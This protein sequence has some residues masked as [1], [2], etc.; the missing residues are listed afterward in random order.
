MS[1]EVELT[2]VLR[3][4][5]AAVLGFVIGR[6]REV[7]EA[8]N[9]A[10]T[11]ALAAL[12]A[13]TLVALTEAL[14]PDETARVVAGIVTGIGFLGAGTILRSPSGEVQGLTTA[15]SLWAMSAIGMAVGSGHEL[16]GV[17]LALVIY[18]TMA[19]SK[20]PVLIRL[21]QLRAQKQAKA[22]GSQPCP[23]PPE[24]EASDSPPTA[25]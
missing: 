14:Y 15:A 5:L 19:I 12:T 6:E 11:V 17:L 13:A 2:I 22:A 9:R 4:A 3:A 1:L 18:A 21:G 25:K 7:L 10:R 8:G 24:G 16:L 23:L 20:W